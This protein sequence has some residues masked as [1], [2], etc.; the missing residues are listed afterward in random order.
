MTATMSLSSGMRERT[1]TRV[2]AISGLVFLTFLALHLVNTALAAVGQAP[3][4]DFQRAARAYYQNLL[5]E[6]VLLLAML[7]HVV[8]GVIRMRRSNA[9]RTLARRLHRWAGVFLAVVVLGHIAAVRGPSL[10]AGIYPGFAGLS[11]SLAWV[12]GYFY[13]YYGLLAMA[14][15]Y[16]AW[17]GAQVAMGRLG[18]TWP[19]PMRRGLGYWLVP[20]AG[21]LVLL[22]ALLG[23]GGLLYPIHDPF[24]N[25]FAHLARSI[26]GD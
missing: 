26:I 18:M 6:P 4:D 7:V 13:P 20:A 5:I 16:H 25:A 15:L 8:V 24:D 12:P 3:Y 1:L 11:F 9:P 23:L 22:T 10:W 17:R 21:G 19:E 2:Q 14:G